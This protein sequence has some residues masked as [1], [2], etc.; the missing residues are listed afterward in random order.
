M[1]PSEQR[2]P[3]R[4]SPTKRHGR[5]AARALANPEA[6]LS[7]SSAAMQ[8]RLRK[9]E[10][11]LEQENPIL[12]KIV[13][14]FRRLD[15]TAY[16]LGLLDRGQSFATLV[17]WWPL[18]SVVGTFSSGKS[19]FINF[20]LGHKLQTT[21]SQAVDDKFTVVCYSNE[22]QSRT[23]P[24]L[25]LDSDPRFPFYRISQAI[26]EVSAG[27]GRRVDAYLQLKTCPSEAL[28]GKILID[29]PGFDADAQRTST[30]RITNH[31]LNLSDLVLVLFDARHP[32]PGA[33]Q[34]TL[35]HLVGGTITR[36]D[37][38]KFLY[39]LNQVDNTAR[40]D[41][42]E[43]VFAAWQRALAQKGLTAGRFYRIYD[44]EAAITIED[45]EVRHRFESKRAADIDEIFERINQ[46]EVERVYRIIGVLE[47]TARAIEGDLVPRIRAAKKRWRR[48]VLWT[49]A[50]VIGSLVLGALAWSIARGYWQGLSFQPPWLESLL[51]NDWLTALAASSVIL[52]TIAI[53]FWVRK[54]TAAGLTKRLRTENAPD[55]HRDWLVAAFA[56][57]TR[58]WRPFLFSKPAGWGHFAKRRVAK[59]L[60]EADSFVQTLNNRFANPSGS[61]APAP[62]A[63][64]VQAQS[65]Q[66]AAGQSTA[67][68]APASDDHAVQAPGEKEA[69][70][71]DARAPADS[72]SFRA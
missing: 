14:S 29:S 65:E 2:P 59:I 70:G 43:E 72:A 56:K 13:H 3:P 11:H 44:P 55:E 67:H 18:I 45:P 24:G 39:V 35:E 21:G 62:A 46:V 8:E 4:A 32:E 42:P 50:V 26:E 34:D 19:T 69:D 63:P 53:H 47:K 57:N 16:K 12:L 10:A 68:D 17:P 60:S 22:G 52:G 30:L 58:P 28:K 20:C 15:K 37:S 48:R 1:W 40:E 23:L 61:T 36:P 27:E 66:R 7:T 31:I 9:L 6:N 54:I 5:A 38:G 71:A 41:N 25:A 51:G 33:M 49:D 64:D